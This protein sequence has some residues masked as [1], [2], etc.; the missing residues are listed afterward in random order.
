MVL[1]WVLSDSDGSKDLIDIAEHCK[2]PYP[3][4]VQA[5]RALETAGLL[6]G[7]LS[8]RAEPASLGV[9]IDRGLLGWVHAR[10]RERPPC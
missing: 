5:A 8:R 7:R 2:F 6:K 9:G 3:Q 1:L 4:V 10:V